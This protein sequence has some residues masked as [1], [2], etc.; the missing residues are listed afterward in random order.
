MNIIAELSFKTIAIEQS[1][2][3]LEIL[4]LTV[5]GSRGHQKEI[6]GDAAKELAEAIACG[7]S[8]PKKA[9]DIL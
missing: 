2:E 7:V 6:A 5:V 9:A 8:L 3:E 4:F 1:H